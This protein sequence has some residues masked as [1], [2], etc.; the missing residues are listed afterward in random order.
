M[1]SVHEQI[2]RDTRVLI[3][4][5][6]KDERVSPNDLADRLFG[7]Y[8]PMG[9][10]PHV[11]YAAIEHLKHI[12]RVE[13]ARRFGPTNDSDDPMQPQLFDGILQRRYPL[14][15]R[16]GEDPIYKLRSLLTPEE[17]AWNVAMLRRRSAGL[18]AH[19]DA[20]EAE[21]RKRAA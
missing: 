11:R 2:L 4:A 16:E 5:M 1:N 6:E 3:D 12:A 18:E 7:K 9:A 8:A 10:E 19:A 14:P 15:Q 13:L 21:G 20:F 17:R